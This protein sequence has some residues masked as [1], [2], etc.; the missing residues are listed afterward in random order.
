MSRVLSGLCFSFCLD[1]L[2]RLP[3][4]ACNPGKHFLS[5][6]AFVRCFYRSNRETNWNTWQVPGCDSVHGSLLSAPQIHTVVPTH[7][8]SKAEFS[9]AEQKRRTAAWPKTA[10]FKLLFQCGRRLRAVDSAL[11]LCLQR[12]WT[13]QPSIFFYCLFDLLLVSKHL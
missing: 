11:L 2:P 13:L 6:V 9:N 10:P 4:V 3:P 8:V 12:E 5:H 1:F 7:Q